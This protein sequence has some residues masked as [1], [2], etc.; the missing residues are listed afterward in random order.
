M[1]KATKITVVYIDTSSE[2]HKIYQAEKRGFYYG[3]QEAGASP[4]ETE[5]AYQKWR[6]KSKPSIYEIA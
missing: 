2:P 3:L 1:K 5:E 6:A 4:E